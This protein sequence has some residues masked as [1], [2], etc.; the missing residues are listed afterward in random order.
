MKSINTIRDNIALYKAGKTE[1]LA[2]A[3]EAWFEL[4]DDVKMGLW[5]APSKGGC[6]T[7]DEREII[8]STEFR[9]SHYGEDNATK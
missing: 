7:T 9:V 6:F 8:K 5:K 2:K 4:S 1:E 3:S